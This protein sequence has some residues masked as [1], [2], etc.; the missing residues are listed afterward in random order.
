M[1]PLLRRHGDAAGEHHCRADGSVTA[2][3][4]GRNGVSSSATSACQGAR[5][6]NA[7]LE[8]RDYVV[9]DFRGGYYAGA[10]LLHEQPSGLCWRRHAS[11]EGLC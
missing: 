3:S 11:F 9:G 4:S 8:G 2:G 7:A 10:R 1:V 5:P 6:V